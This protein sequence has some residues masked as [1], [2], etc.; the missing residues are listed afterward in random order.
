MRTFAS[1]TPARGSC[2]TRRGSYNDDVKESTLQKYLRAFSHIEGWFS[3]DAALMFMAY[4]QVLASRGIAGNALEIGVH[5]GLSTI[6]VAALRPHSACLYVVDLFEQLQSENA[7]RSG[8][9]NRAIFEQNMQNFFG[10]TDFVVPLVCR[11]SSLSRADFQGDFSFCHVDGGHSRSETLHD[12]ELCSSLLVP[13][14]LLALDDYF[15]PEFPGVCEGAVEF[16]VRHPA[17]LVPVAFAYN[18]V[19]FQKLP[20]PFD[21]NAAFWETFPP[22]PHKVIEMWSSPAIL[23]T[24]VFRSYFDLYASTPQELVPMGA[25][26]PRAQFSPRDQ[27]LRARPAASIT[28]PIEV[29][30]ISKEIFPAGDRVFGLSYRLLAPNGAVLRHDNERAYIQDPIM[31]GGRMRVPL[32]IQTPPD[33]GSYKVEVDLVWEQV[34]WFK[35]VG[36]PTSILELKVS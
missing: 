9:G 30:N 11:S 12:L 29:V 27:Q 1:S 15:N 26:G 13:G 6:A 17:E 23:F 35:D 20:A 4:H 2:I 7:S 28:V 21:L 25:V 33:R 22:I 18:K 8:S 31:P 32:R 19:L 5:H 34:M 14:G 3:Y 16:L 24:S 36:N 10:C